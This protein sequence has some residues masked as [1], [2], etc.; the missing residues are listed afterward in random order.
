MSKWYLTAGLH[1][2]LT[3]RGHMYTE[4][5]LCPRL[6]MKELC[7]RCFQYRE[8]N[9]S[10]TFHE[11]VPAHRMSQATAFEAARGLV[12]SSANWPQTFV[13]NSLLNRSRGGPECYPGFNT[14]PEYP[15]PGVMR[16]N[17]SVGNDWAWFDKVINAK[18]FRKQVSTTT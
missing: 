15:E 8:G 13:L 3:D 10:E 9:V 12:V 14:K 18:E 6:K 7:F 17:V 2:G 1:T 4:H 11:H 5:K 16:W